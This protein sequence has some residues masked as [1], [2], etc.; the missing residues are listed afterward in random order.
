MQCIAARCCSDFFSPRVPDEE[1]WLP[2]RLTR[3]NGKGITH[4]IGWSGV[5]VA[6]VTRAGLT[7]RDRSLFWMGMLNRRRE[8]DGH[9]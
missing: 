9:T 2:L 7:Q 8:A 6:E 5:I 4:L 3:Y 1:A